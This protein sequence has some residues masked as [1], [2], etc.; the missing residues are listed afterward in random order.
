MTPLER[1][2]QRYLTYLQADL[3]KSH[4]TI[5]NY[6][7][8]LRFMVFLCPFLKTY[9]DI[10]KETVRKYKYELKGYTTAKGL[11]LSTSTR[12]HHLTI[13]RAFLR[14]LIQ[15][16]ELPAYP[17]DRIGLLRQE[18][19]RVKVL[20]HDE[21]KRLINMPDENTITGLRDKAIISLFFSS[22]MR[23]AELHSLNRRDINTETRELC[24][25]GKG[26]KLRPVFFSKGTAKTLTEYLEQRSD[27]LNPLFISNHRK[28]ETAMP[29]G[30]S[31]RLSYRQIYN[32]VVKYAT[33]AG[34]TILPSPHTLRHSFA[35]D[36]LR[37]GADL[38]MVKEL[39][40]HKDVKTTQI[41]THITNKSLK[42]TFFK[43]HG[44]T[45]LPEKQIGS[46]NTP[47]PS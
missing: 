30:E 23:R 33:K 18:D 44:H 5:N 25:R 12:N 8:S 17:P 15:E 6:R 46:N 13:L 19:R 26:G 45:P 7:D 11:P 27:H 39:L 1:A 31:F 28:A 38:M 29:P 35:T 22:G 16:E 42:D 34:L 3:N 2:V 9:E 36:L 43:F 21:I 4:L 24:I 40:G 14:Y 20:Y 47:S 32:I 37:N 10:N 41:Y